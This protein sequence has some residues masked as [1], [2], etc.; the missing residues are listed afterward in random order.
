MVNEVVEKINMNNQYKL[1]G[2]VGLLLALT[3][4]TG[5]ST[6]MRLGDAP[7][8]KVATLSMSELQTPVEH[9][10]APEDQIQV[11][12]WDV[13][14]FTSAQAAVQS[15]VAKNAGFNYVIHDDGGI[16]LPLVGSLMLAG[17]TVPQARDLIEVRLRE[18]V[19]NPKIGVTVSQY[20]SRKILLLGEVGKP[21]IVVNPGS[22]LSLAEA[23]A[24]AGG[25]L[26]LSANTSNVYIIRGALDQPKVTRVEVG[27]AVAMF[28]AQHIWL[29]SRDVVFVNSLGI[30]D[31]NRFMSQL[32]PTFTDYFMLKS[33]GVLK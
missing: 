14:E 27:T 30:T 26:T 25:V 6:G 3:A 21:G 12:V 2:V 1:L 28:Q 5:C 17:L 9:K 13:P 32:I 20:N 7:G 16:D 33:V 19:T 11:V 31:W 29:Q 23:L 18:F 10:L 8:V 22:R 24:Q 4:L 15:G